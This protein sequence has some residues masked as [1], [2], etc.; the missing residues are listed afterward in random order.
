MKSRGWALYLLDIIKAGSGPDARGDVLVMD[1]GRRL[2]CFTTEMAPGH[3]LWV[4]I[5]Y[6]IE[7]S[8]EI[9][10]LHG[11]RADIVAMIR[12]QCSG[13]RICRDEWGDLGGVGDLIRP[14]DAPGRF[15]PRTATPDR[16]S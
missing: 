15:L 16:R 11:Q 12:S 9:E 3:H 6:S 10:V 2:I 4:R 7:P 8:P 13:F 14:L 5:D 1:E